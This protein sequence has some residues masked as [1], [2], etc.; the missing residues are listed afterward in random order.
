[1]THW[2]EIA[3]GGVLASSDVIV[4]TAHRTK[5]RIF[6]QRF[7]HP[8]SE[9]DFSDDFWASLKIESRLPPT[10]GTGTIQG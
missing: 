1:L 5:A 2:V 3:L 9:F 6:S 7:D 4:P 8:S 10:N